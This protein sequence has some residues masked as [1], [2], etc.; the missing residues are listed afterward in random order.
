MIDPTRVPAIEMTEQ[1]TRFIIKRSEFRPSDNTVKPKLFCPYWR[2]ELSVNRLRDCSQDETWRFGQDVANTR[3]STLYGRSDI[4]VASCCIDP[5]S[6]VA[7]PLEGNPN[8]ADITNYPPAKEDQTSLAQ[9]LAA[10]A[11]KRI[12]PPSQANE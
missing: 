5:L 1:L 7:K 9:K 6:V 4:S 2:T 8:H 10:A 11:S 12:I 3:E